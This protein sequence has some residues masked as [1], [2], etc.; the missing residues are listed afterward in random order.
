MLQY[1]GATND[2]IGD[3]WHQVVDA[4]PRVIGALL[5]LLI[6]YIV[7]KAVSAL[8]QKALERARLDEHI[9]SGKGGN[10]LQRAVPHP[11]SCV[12]KCNNFWSDFK[13]VKYHEYR[14]AHNN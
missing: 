10:V 9:H 13:L 12:G 2:Y 6:G 1:F 7:A 4:L 14:Q 8:V 5:L 3:F 11:S